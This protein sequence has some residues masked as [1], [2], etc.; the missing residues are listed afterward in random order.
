[1]ASPR[2]N[3]RLEKMVRHEI[4]QSSIGPSELAGLW[5]VDLGVAALAVAERITAEFLLVRSSDE[6]V[7]KIAQALHD[8]G[9]NYPWSV[10]GDSYKDQRRNQARAVLSAITTGWQ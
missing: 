9:A 6:T 2:I 3:K 5:E 1:M 7:E 10:A 4:R 8:E